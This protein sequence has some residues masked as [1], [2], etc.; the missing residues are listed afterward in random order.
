MSDLIN[1]RYE[2]RAALDREL[3]EH[4]SAALREAIDKHGTAS[5][6]VSGG[7]TPKGVFSELSQQDLDWSSVTITLVDD[8]WVDPTHEDS[9][10]LLVNTFLRTSR[11]AS[12][13]FVSLHSDHAH[14]SEA[15][16][17]IESRL[18]AF[19][20]IDV[21]MLGMG[22]DGHFA[23]LFPDSDVLEQG[24]NLAGDQACIAVDPPVAPHA[25][26]SMTLPRIFDS[27]FLILHITGD[28][29]LD[30]LQRAREQQ[31]PLV[32]PIAAVLA[33]SAPDLAI[34]WAP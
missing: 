1:H 30:V 13:Q 26:M 18:N 33:S 22:G 21:M 24:L 16:P 34:Y 3:A 11:A 25:R 2:D 7:S 9:N 19:D 6:A 17:V 23:S 10:E 31:D 15:Q 32:L 20:T 8:R 29:K 27:R 12:A 5:M 28:D 4:I 14:P